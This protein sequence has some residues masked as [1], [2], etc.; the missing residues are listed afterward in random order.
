MVARLLQPARH[1][2]L[3]LV[4][5]VRLVEVPLPDAG[6]IRLDPIG[7]AAQELVDRLAGDLADRVP[8]RVLDAAPPDQPVPQVAFDGEEVLADEQPA[9][10]AQHLRGARP[11]ER[12]PAN[13]RVGL[14]PHD[15]EIVVEAG[16]TLGRR[17]RDVDGEDVHVPD[18]DRLDRRGQQP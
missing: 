18:L 14:D 4:G 17:D 6:D 11:R 8:D 2:G 9:N 10:L 5:D 16:I 12:V 1:R 3:V 13:A 15:R 7:R